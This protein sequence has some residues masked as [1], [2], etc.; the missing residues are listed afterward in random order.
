VHNINVPKIGRRPRSKVVEL[1][2]KMPP[3]L[4]PID[5]AKKNLELVRQ[6]VR[7]VELWA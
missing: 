3:P 1:S 7:T 5:K 2:L 4:S 6:L